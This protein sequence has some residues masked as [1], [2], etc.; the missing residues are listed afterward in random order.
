MIKPHRVSS[1]SGAFQAIE[2]AR[3]IPA[4]QHAALLHSGIHH[5]G[6]QYHQGSVT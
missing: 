5:L 3:Y 6:R 4:Y 2:Q 1:R